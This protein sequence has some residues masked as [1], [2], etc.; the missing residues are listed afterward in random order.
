MA[1][2]AGVE[3]LVARVNE[4]VRSM[5]FGN[6][7]GQT[8]VE[9][10]GSFDTQ[11]WLPGTSDVDLM[12]MNAVDPFSPMRCASQP[13]SPSQLTARQLVTQ[14]MQ[15]EEGMAPRAVV[16][17]NAA[18]MT[19]EKEAAA[20]ARVAGRTESAVEDVKAGAASGFDRSELRVSTMQGQHEVA[21]FAHLARELE[22]APFAEQVMLIETAS[23]P[24]IKFVGLV[25]AE[26]EGPDAS[27]ARPVLR[28][29]FDVIMEAPVSLAVRALCWPACV[30]RRC[31][32]TPLPRCCC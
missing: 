9:L 8:F 12:L 4:L 18:A 24:V 16:V 7:R 3:R 17:E 28:V 23:V 20:A 6:A 29:P 31:A 1:V 15:A 30:A 13:P 19:Q 11:L 14:Q 32:A 21:A 27:G 5:S 2:H 10:Y 22:H 26:D 25:D